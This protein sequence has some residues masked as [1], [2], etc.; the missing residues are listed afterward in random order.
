[1]KVAAIFAGGVGSRMSLKSLPMHFLEIYD[2]PVVVRALL[3]FP[4]HP[5]MDAI[6]VA[7]LPEDTDYLRSL[8]VKYDLERLS[9]IVEGGANGL[10]SR[11][12]VR[13]EISTHV[14]EESVVV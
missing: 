9:W 8:V 14:T 11:R 4:M 6:A 2:E 3:H 12:K 5:D 10:E 13:T 7:M 1:M